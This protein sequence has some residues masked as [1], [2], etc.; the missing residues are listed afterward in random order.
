MK[1]IEV[2]RADGSWQRVARED[3]IERTGTRDLGPMSD[4]CVSLWIG[5]TGHL[6]NLYP[7]REFRAVSE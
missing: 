7:G 4:A 2:K 5:P 6:T 1:Y 3:F